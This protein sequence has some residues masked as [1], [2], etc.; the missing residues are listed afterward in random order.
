MDGKFRKLNEL[1]CSWIKSALGLG[2]PS[3][4][5]ED[6]LAVD[7]LQELAEGDTA[8]NYKNAPD[9]GETEGDC[10]ASTRRVS[11]ECFRRNPAGP[12]VG[13]RTEQPH[14]RMGDSA[15]LCG[16]LPGGHGYLSRNIGSFTGRHS[17]NC[18]RTYFLRCRIRARIRRFLRPILRRPRPVFFTPTEDF[19]RKKAMN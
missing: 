3:A 16:A 6:N 17:R 9:R 1:N 14:S 10:R 11:K 19:L 4:R 8:N 15:E 18:S 2:L 13:R 7:E 5:F 12:R